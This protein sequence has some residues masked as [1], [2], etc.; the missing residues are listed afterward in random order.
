MSA[1]P[2][3]PVFARVAELYDP[4]REYTQR[5]VEWVADN[6][7]E[8]LWAK[9]REIAESV[10]DYRY[11]AVHSA[12]ET[13][14]SFN[15]SRLAAWWIDSHA[16]GDAFVVSTAPSAAQ[17]S[18]VLWRE[19]NKIHKLAKLPGRINRAGYPQWFIDG[20]LVGYGRK[21]A[22]HE[23]SA[24]QGIH[25]RYVLIIIDEACGVV[26]QLYDAVDSIAANENARVL[27]I[28]NPDDETSYFKKICDPTSDERWDNIIRVDGLRTPNFTDEGTRAFPLVRQLMRAERIPFNTE[29][30]PPALREYLLSPQWVEERIHR[31]AG[32]NATEILDD[33]TLIRRCATSA[34]FDAK[35]RGSFPTSTSTGV[36]PLGWIQRAV[37]RWHDWKDAG[38]QEV[39]GRRVVGIDVARGGDD[40]SV[41][42]I[43][44][45]NVVRELFAFHNSDTTET[46]E[47][48]SRYLNVPEA[49]AVVDVIGIGA[50][51]FDLLRKWASTG[52]IIASCIAFNAAA[53]S[54]RTDRLGEFRFMN[55]RAAAWWNMRELLDPSRGSQVAL[56]DDEW[57]IQELSAPKYSHYVGGR[58]KVEPKED[59]I[60]RLGR[61]T[62]RADAVV[63]SFWVQGLPASNED[64]G[65]RWRAPSRDDGIVRY[66]DMPSFSE[67]DVNMEAERRSRRPRRKLPGDDE[68]FAF[69]GGV[70]W[71]LNP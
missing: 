2:I 12:H 25:A 58:I 64:L 43:R 45:G 17:V 56:P 39:V 44:H 16:P 49:M 46:A 67:T 24:F 65:Q 13:G 51:V 34:L 11:T 40:E 23:Q 8:Y 26:K 71:E 29:D 36:I 53:Q 1:P 6:S 19:I 35:V 9:Q 66:A 30:V 61:S 15:A 42:A 55:D 70:D 48:A 68:L 47:H 59:I 5:P 54:G 41:I 10:R 37:E 63:Q 14:K 32:V 21:P 38:E 60:K 22:D 62:D 52:S 69:S 50:G 33:A 28:G 20:D 18:A 4:A 57:L 7:G 31:W 3:D 27:A